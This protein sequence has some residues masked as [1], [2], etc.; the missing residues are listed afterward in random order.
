MNP[1]ESPKCVSGPFERRALPA[2]PI[3]PIDRVPNQRTNECGFGK[4]M[5]AVRDEDVVKRRSVF[6][7][8]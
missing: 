7:Q 3:D 4:C 8:G 6:A 1:I 5:G 2:L